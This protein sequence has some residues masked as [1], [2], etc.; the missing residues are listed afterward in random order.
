MKLKIDID[1]GKNRL[2]FSISRKITK[3]ELDKFYTDLR[4][5]VADLQPDFDVIG[6]FSECDIIYLS[7]TPTF[8]N[9]MCYLITKRIRENIL[10][11]KSN[12]LYMQLNNLISILNIYI[13]SYVSTLQEAEDILSTDQR[14]NGLRICLHHNLAE[15]L[16]DTVQVKNRILD[17][18]TSGCSLE[19]GSTQP[20]VGQEITLNISLKDKEEAINKFSIPATAV[21]ITNDMFA[22]KYVHLDDDQKD[23][24]WSCLLYE[25]NLLI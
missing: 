24:L 18:S 19:L 25:S 6:D 12:L 20:S 15:Y 14:R 4:F 10:V 16:I 1:T 5:C 23:Q 8:R 17:M 22:V 3:T 9:I 2:Y 7:S 21:R 11:V 13:P